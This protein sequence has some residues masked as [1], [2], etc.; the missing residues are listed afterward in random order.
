MRNVLALCMLAGGLL[1]LTGCPPAIDAP[2]PSGNQLMQEYF[3]LAKGNTWVYGLPPRIFGDDKLLVRVEVLDELQ[4]GTSK[5]PFTA[6]ETRLTDLNDDSQSG[7]VFY[8]YVNDRL[9]SSDSTGVLDNL[10]DVSGLT[11]VDTAILP[12]AID[13]PHPLAAEID[14]GENLR[15][16][17][18]LLNDF[19]P[20]R[21]TIEG[22]PVRYEARDFPIPAATHALAETVVL[23]GTPRV[24]RFL[25]KGYGRILISVA[26][27]LEGTVN[28]ETVKALPWPP[29][30]DLVVDPADVTRDIFEAFGLQHD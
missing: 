22:V 15:Y 2:R 25:A 5:Q 29:E 10:P 9:Y 13:V 14:E 12:A 16:S 23:E 30:K 28:G 1:F 19:M 21:F 4:V 7:T 8:V 18:A 11:L 17:T 26:V 3:P 24:L 27:L 6:Y 20:L